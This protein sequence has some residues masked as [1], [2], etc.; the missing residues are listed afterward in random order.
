MTRLRVSDHAVL[1]WLQ[2]VEGVNVE[3]IRRRIA[4]AARVGAGHQA[5]GIRAQGVTYKLQ[6][7]PGEAVVTTVT[8][9]HPRPHLAEPRFSF[10]EM[11]RLLQAEANT[12]VANVADDGALVTFLGLP[13]EPG[14]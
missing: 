3:A 13:L 11:E 8:S 10:V 1:R 7:N 4:E 6:Y 14:D 12:L 9:P 5:E 2:R